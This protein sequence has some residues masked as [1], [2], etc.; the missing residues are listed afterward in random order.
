ME[1]ANEIT[2]TIDTLPIG[3]KFVDNYTLSDAG[4]ARLVLGI[5]ILFDL[6]MPASGEKIFDPFH[7]GFP[8][9]F[10]QHLKHL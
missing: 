8:F 4:C 9:C 7:S 10:L 2:C 6:K 1:S 5:G 3:K